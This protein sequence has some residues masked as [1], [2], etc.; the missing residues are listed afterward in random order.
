MNKYLKFLVILL[1][2]SFI[3]PQVAFASW[4]NPFSWNIWH[5]NKHQTVQ[6]ETPSSSTPACNPNWQC[7][8]WSTCTRSLQTRNCIDANSCGVLTDKP[9]I[10]QSCTSAC[11]PNWKCSSWDNCSNSLQTRTCTDSNGCGSTSGKPALSQACLVT[12]AITTPPPATNQ[13]CTDLENEYKDFKNKMN[14]IGS[15][16]SSIGKEFLNYLGCWNT[17]DGSDFVQKLA[18]ASYCYNKV[19][20]NK[21][22]FSNLLQQFT[23][24]VD[25]LPSLSFAD[26]NTIKQTL[27]SSIQSLQNSYNSLISWFSSLIRIAQLKSQNL[28]SS[29]AGNS[30]QRS[31][32]EAFDGSTAWNTGLTSAFNSYANIE[33][34]YNTKHDS[35][36]PK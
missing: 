20:T 24:Q 9:P 8:T 4:W 26:T 32:E 7:E 5:F 3:V 27:Y 30:A 33:K 19:N 28:D 11:V 15:Q 35:L 23:R 14:L 16:S 22:S 31:M 34:T 10:A 13:N 29:Y 21:D 2:V 6:T 17:G 1:A 18:D 12:P 36:C 25:G